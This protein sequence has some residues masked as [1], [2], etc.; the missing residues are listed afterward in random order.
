MK[1]PDL[2]Q[3][4]YRFLILNGSLHLPGVGS[5]EILHLPAINDLNNH[6]ILPPSTVT[7]FSEK[8]TTSDNS[9]LLNY[10]VRHLN[11][12][13]SSAASMLSSFCNSIEEKLSDG[14]TVFWSGLGSIMKSSNG[15]IVFENEKRESE[16]LRDV[17][18]NYSYNIDEEEESYINSNSKKS[19]KRTYYSLAHTGFV[20]FKTAII[21]LCSIILIFILVRYSFGNFDL[22]G[23][24][25]EKVELL[26]PH[27]TY[28]II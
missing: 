6:K 16:L 25:Y 13:Q 17:D 15:Q 24:R 27:S 7:K 10:L 1:E 28:K 18:T 12:P 9:A 3:Y 22:F 14:K 2:S 21:L 5:F 20:D 4:I 23:S 19:S 26:V 8:N 11:V